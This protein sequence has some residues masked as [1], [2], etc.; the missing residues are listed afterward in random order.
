MTSPSTER[1][2]LTVAQAAEMTGLSADSIR[3]AYRSGGLPVRYHG[4]KVLIR[5]EDLAVWVDNL[6][7]ERPA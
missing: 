1:V 7:T 3:A 5:H 2:S 4:A 6:P